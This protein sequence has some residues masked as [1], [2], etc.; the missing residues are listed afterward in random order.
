[1]RNVGGLE[2]VMRAVFGTGY[3]LADYL[4]SVKN[5]ILLLGLGLWG[6]LTSAIGYCP[7]N[8]M[9]GRSTCAVDL[10]PTG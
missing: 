8:S 9:L 7:F 1:M 5:E 6:V 4:A 3:V 10:Q 2:R